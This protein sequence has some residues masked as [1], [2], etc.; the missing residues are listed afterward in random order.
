MSTK[1][2]DYWKLFRPKSCNL[3]LKGTTKEEVLEEIVEHLEKNGSLP[4]ELREAGHKALL[5]RERMAS[6]GVGMNVAIPH[7]KLEGLDEVV[8]SL[9]LHLD[10][11]EWSALDGEPVRI[12]FTVLRP[13]KATAGY[14]PERH[15]DMMRW[16]SRLCREADF[17]RFALSVSNRTELCDLLKEKSGA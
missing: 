1:T 8:V 14:D 4:S 11:V 2:S 16:L 5:D 10:G 6:T 9:C 3:K 7:V 12:L 13:A 15:L 17:R